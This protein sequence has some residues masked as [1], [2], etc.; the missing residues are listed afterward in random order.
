M[1]TGIARWLLAAPFVV[2]GRV[3]LEIAGVEMSG[4]GERGT[5]FLVA[6]SVGL[7]ESEGLELLASSM[8]VVP[9]WMGWSGR[10]LG[11]EGGGDVVEQGR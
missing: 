8:A 3:E 11:R 9:Q 7:V 4:A 6:P 2:E 10:E 1:L 5:E